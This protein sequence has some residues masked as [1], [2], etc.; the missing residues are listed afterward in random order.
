MAGETIKTAAVC[1]GIHPWSRT[2]HVTSWLTPAGRIV[3][4]VKGAVRPKSAFLG[5]YDLNYTCEILYYARARGELHALR[6]CTPL[7][8]RDE[9]RGDYRRLVLAEHFRHLAAELAPSGPDAAEW[10]DLLVESLD[11]LRVDSAAAL[12][13]R[14]LEFERRT[15]ELSGVWPD[16]PTD[17]CEIELQN[18]RR[19]PVPAA[20]AGCLAAPFGTGDVKI[21][22]DAARVIS[23]LYALNLEL[24][25]DSR[26]SV[27][28]LICKP[29][30]EKAS[31]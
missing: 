3:T 5:Q 14:M 21:L 26:R 15:L 23:V 6:E 13:P 4:V 1:L 8:T 10:F 7:N 30:Q 27:L 31:K 24:A 11:A 20:T 16:I 19:I 9:L 25:S 28:Q 22:L 12:L 29:E 18:D 17:G 2:S